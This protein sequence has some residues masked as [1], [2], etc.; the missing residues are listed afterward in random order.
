[1]TLYKKTLWIISIVI[2]VMLVFIYGAHQIVLMGSFDKIDEQYSLENIELAKNALDETIK[3]LD[4]TT[5]DWAVWDDAY[6]FV[7]DSNENF[8]NSY[9]NADTNSDLKVNLMVFMKLS[10]KLAGSFAFD[11]E[12]QTEVP[13]PGY[14]SGLSQSDVL[15]QYK[16]VAGTSKGIIHLPEGPMLVSSWPITNN[17]K[18]PVGGTLI[19]GRYLDESEIRRLSEITHLNLTIRR[20]D[21]EKMPSDF[22]AAFSSLSKDNPVFIQKLSD[23][24]IGGYALLNDIYGNPAII[25][26]VETPRLVHEQGK[27]T[28]DYFIL[29]FLIIGTTFVAFFLFLFKNLVLSKLASLDAQVQGIS[30]SGDN[31]S[32][33]S[34]KRVGNLLADNRTLNWM[35]NSFTLRNKTLLI[36]GVVFFIMIIL[37]FAVSQIIFMDRFTRLEENY[38]LQKVQ[39]SMDVLNDEIDKLNSTE[40][41]WA[42]WNDTYIFINDSN[43]EYIQSN[44]R[45]EIFTNIRIN[46]MLFMNS[47][48]NMV[49]GKA[50][51]LRNQT[52]VSVPRYFKEEL[53]SDNDLLHFETQSSKTGILVVPEGPMLVASQPILQNDGTGPVRGTLIMGSF[54]NSEEIKWFSGITKL[55]ISIYRFDDKRMPSDLQ[56]VL[57]FFSKDK[58]IYV[59]PVNAESIAGYAL[60]DDIYGKPGII[61]KV[62]M[63]RGIY[64]QGKETLSYFIIY[65]LIICSVF[66][67]VIVVLLEIFVLRR[68]NRL[69]SDVKNIEKSGNNSSRVVVEGKDELSNLAGSLNNMLDA[70]E[71]SQEK[72]SKSE[73]KNRAILEAIPDSILQIRKNGTIFNFKA[74]KDKNQSTLTRE[75]IGRN[76]RDVMPQNIAEQIL[77]NIQQ[78]L[79]TKENQIFQYQLMEKNNL[80]YYEARIVDFKEEAVLVIIADITERKQA[81]VA[82][83]ISERKYSTLVEKGNDGI[84]II[85]DGLLE[86]ANS[87]MAQI[88]GYTIE[89]VIGKSIIDFVSLEYKELVIENYK[90]RFSGEEILN[91]YEIEIISK[92]GRKIPVEINASLIDYEGEKVEMAIIRDIT[93]HKRT[94]GALREVNSHL[95]TL[96]NNLNAGILVENEKHAIMHV[97]K[98]FCDMFSIPLWPELLIGVDCS[99]SIHQIKVLFADPEEFVA[100]VNTLLTNRQTVTGEVLNL[101]DGRVFERDFIPVYFE[102]VFVGHMWQYRDITERKKI[103][104]QIEASLHEKETL[105]K[106]IHHRVK[107]NMQIVSSLLDHQIQYIKDN[108]VIH[109]FKDSQNRIA[110]MA[111]VHEKLYQSKDL[112]KINVQDYINDLVAN[113]FQSY[114]NDPGKIKLNMN[115]ENIELDIDFAIPCGLIINE[116]VTNSLKYAFPE[117]RFGEIKIVF[118]KTGEDM[119]ELIIGDNGIGLPLDMDF[120]KTGSLGLHLVTILAENQLDGEIKLIRNGG[121]EFQIKFI[122]IR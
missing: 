117:G 115:V 6:F 26:K 38:S 14:F 82:L 46:L 41:D 103:E 121:M 60:I 89:E 27:E 95:K 72:V 102:D 78:T 112:A 55:P 114:M 11:L 50:F 98:V 87:K 37:L 75:C 30:R 65:L 108:N 106:E 24:S 12:N 34:M 13:V 100:R 105:L 84:I 64:K 39:F 42:S 61:L 22:Q 79:L 16:G 119:L 109:I 5:G 36:M 96:I 19:M 80:Y 51:D 113:L 25:L 52:E 49:Y 104:K 45:L 86:F 18:L 48:G 97:N 58:P 7:N 59:R 31:S 81:E 35:D 21:D 43:E 118:R 29:L 56:A 63:P 10:G 57:P 70:L 67:I 73:A 83:Q 71:Q 4:R 111:L 15:L 90:K 62:E 116:L 94:E 3:K 99:Q 122:G 53:S 17:G 32:R 93:E 69:D 33:V 20:T 88:A 28:M 68:L 54:L 107:N 91:N 23:K 101:A 2:A 85:K 74:A 92:D 44:I 9:L 1:M 120:R 40:L 76:I 66:S 110:S 8:S 77:N 47:S